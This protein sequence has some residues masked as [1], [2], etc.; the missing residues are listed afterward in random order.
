MTVLV[1]Q[2]DRLPALTVTAVQTDGT[3]YDLTG[4]SIVFN[5]RNAETGTVKVSRAAA[6]LVS[7]PNGTMRYEWAATDLDT[8]GLYEAEFEA[9]IA[10]KKLSIPTDGF[11][12]IRVLDD[13]A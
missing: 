8:V 10:S 13:I 3:P 1:K 5:M 6:T 4:A 12:P 11:I 7:G 9:T 2:N